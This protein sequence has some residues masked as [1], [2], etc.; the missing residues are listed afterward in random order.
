[1]TPF[2]R[3]L[4]K[5]IE[6]QKRQQNGSNAMVGDGKTYPCSCG[7]AMHWREFGSDICPK[8]GNL[9]VYHATEHKIA[10]QPTK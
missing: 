3:L 4:T 6:H 1:M 7:H 9:H 10:H 2:A 8:C 5:A